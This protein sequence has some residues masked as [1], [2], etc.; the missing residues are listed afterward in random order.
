MPTRAGCLAIVILITP[1][2]QV[3]VA[4]QVTIVNTRPGTPEVIGTVVEAESLRP[5]PNPTITLSDGDGDVLFTFSGDSL[6]AF[7]FPDT[8]IG[9]VQIAVEQIGYSRV[10]GEVNVPGD[11]ALTLR[12]DLP[13]SPVPLSELEAL[14]RARPRHMEMSLEGFTARS[15]SVRGLFFDEEEIEQRNPSRVTDL[16]MRAPEYSLLRYRGRPVDVKVLRA[17]G[18][19]FQRGIMPCLPTIWL[20]GLLVREGGFR[21]GDEPG[22][23]FLNDLINPED[24]GGIEVYAGPAQTPIQFRG[25]G[26]MCGVV[27]VW[28]RR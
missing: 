26:S 28:S 10:E 22:L 24:I 21:K 12:V 1:T 20:D 5:V 15:A 13:V 18:G 17:Q 11:R 3:P 27:V 4:G 2:L 19:G 16:V 8:S 23:L 25:T 7:R 6:G 14:V 9:T